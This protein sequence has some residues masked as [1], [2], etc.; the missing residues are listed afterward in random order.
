MLTIVLPMALEKP[1]LLNFGQSKRVCGKEFPYLV[2]GVGIEST[3]RALGKWASDYSNIYDSDAGN[4]SILLLG[5][6]GGLDPSL[7]SGDMVVSTYYRLDPRLPEG[8]LINQLEPNQNMFLKN[9]LID[10]IVI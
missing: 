9:M 4:N 2:V 8:R 5:F 6:C 7:R 10:L 3:Q 1:G